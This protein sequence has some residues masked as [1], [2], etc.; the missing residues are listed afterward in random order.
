M[1]EEQDIP[2]VFALVR[3]ADESRYIVGYGMV[4]PDG[5]T[6]SLSWPTG[7]G[8]SFYS[9]SSAEEAAA[10]RGATVLWT[11]EQ[12]R[13]ATPGNGELGWFARLTR[14]VRR[15]LGVGARTSC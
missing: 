11:C 2:K 4:L 10:V 3:D 6:Y 13:W 1:T 9:A 12:P 8:T 7:R 15:A 5:S 14:A